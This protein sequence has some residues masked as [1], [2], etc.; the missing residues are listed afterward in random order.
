MVQKLHRPQVPSPWQSKIEGAGG[1]CLR[2][3]SALGNPE[4]IKVGSTFSADE[5]LAQR[6]DFMLS[7]ARGFAKTD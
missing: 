3:S 1:P 4:N 7:K 5:F 2:H 6:F